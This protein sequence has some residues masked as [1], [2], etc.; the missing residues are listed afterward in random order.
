ME[1]ENKIHKDFEDL[2]NKHFVEDDK[3]IDIVLNT[4]CSKKYNLRI[5][6]QKCCLCHSSNKEEL[7][8]K[9]N[10]IKFPCKCIKFMHKSCIIAEVSQEIGDLFSNKAKISCNTCKKNVSL[11]KFIDNI[12]K[13]S[14]DNEL[15]SL[16]QQYICPIC[17][18]SIQ[19]KSCFPCK[20]SQKYHHLCLKSLIQNLLITS[21]PLGKN[22]NLFEI[23]CLTCKKSF[24]YLKLSKIFTTSELSEIQESFTKQKINNLKNSNPAAK[25]ELECG[26]CFEEKNVDKEFITLEC[27]HKFCKDCLEGYINTEIQKGEYIHNQNKNVSCPNCKNDIDLQIINNVLS[28]KNLYDKYE[29]SIIQKELE[30]ENRKDSTEKMIRCPNS[31]CQYF[32]FIDTKITSFAKCPLCDLEFCV[33]GCK[34]VHKGNTCAQ[35]KKQEEKENDGAMKIDFKQCPNCNI[36]IQKSK[37]CNHITCTCGTQFCYVCGSTEWK[38]CGHK[39]LG[40]TR[41]ELCNPF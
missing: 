1:V 27:E 21:D 23:N 11:L 39:Y 19:E 34:K 3:D 15:K 14:A 36:P 33:N 30:K 8:T 18:L 25:K 29:K 4:L 7:I 37:G 2:L 24:D 22:S 41:M 13:E 40:V 38:T 20:C 9:T 12:M 17:K 10:S 6:P 28:D 16:L 32:C 35:M 5:T 26:I 31:T